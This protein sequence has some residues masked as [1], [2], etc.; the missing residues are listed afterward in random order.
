MAAAHLLRCANPEKLFGG[1]IEVPWPVQLVAKLRLLLAVVSERR[2][3]T[4]YT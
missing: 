1:D 4:T 2:V 3:K